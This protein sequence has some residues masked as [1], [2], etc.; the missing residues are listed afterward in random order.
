[1]VVPFFTMP[2][3]PD[4]ADRPPPWKAPSPLPAEYLTE[5]LLLRFWRPEDALAMLQSIEVDRPSLSPWLPW[6]AVDNRTVAEC[7]ATIARM[8][9][10][11]ERAEPPADSFAIGIFD[12]RTGEALGG[13]GLH[14]IVHAFHEAEVGYWVRADRRGRGICGEAV[15]GLLTWAFTPEA[16]GGWGLRRIHIRCAGRNLASQRVPRKLGL[17]EEARLVQERWVEGIGWDDTLVWG[18]LADEWETSAS[19]LRRG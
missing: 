7:G 6:A 19:R 9:A 16:A 4:S 13:T 8:Q 10:E 2:D 1:M 14:R 18:V 5:R 12:R 11:R 3:H 15:A 17:R